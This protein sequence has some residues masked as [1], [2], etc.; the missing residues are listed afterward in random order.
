[1]LETIIPFYGIKIDRDVIKHLIP[2]V[3]NYFKDLERV[4]TER[5]DFSK[6]AIVGTSSYTTSLASSLF[7]LRW[8]KERHSQI[9]TV[10]GGGVF[11]NDLALGSENLDI[12]IR[13]YLYVDHVIIGEGEILL[14]E[15]ARGTFAHKRIVSLADIGGRSLEMNQVLAPDFSDYDLEPY[16]HLSIEGAR[17]CPFQCKFCSETV[18]WGDYRKKPIDL[19]VHQTISLAERFKN[20]SFFMGDS[21]MN[22][23]IM[24]FSDE[25]VKRKA[26]IL[27]DGYLRA[28]KP[29]I[30]RERVKKWARSG[31]FRVRLGIESASRRILGLMDKFTTPETISEVLKSLSSAGIRTT[32]YWICGFPGETEDD[33][34]ETLE[35]IHQHSRYIYELEPH[36]HEYFPY[37]QVQSREYECYSLY[38]DEITE[39]IKFKVWE[40]SN[41]NPSREAKYDRLR[42]LSKVASD[43]GLVNIYTMEDRY[44][45]EERWHSLSALAR[46]IYKGSQLRR[47]ESCLSESTVDKI[48]RMEDSC[49]VGETASDNVV[50]C[51]YTLVKKRLAET[52]LSICINQ[53]LRY[54]DVMWMRI[55]N[56]QLAS[57]NLNGVDYA[58]RILSVYTLREE[59][60]L[61][62]AA[63]EITAAFSLQAR[64]EPGESLRIALIYR[65]NES[66][67]LLYTHQDI[68]DGKGLT[69]LM[70]DLYRIYEQISNDRDISLLP[71]ET[72]YIDMMNELSLAGNS[73]A[74]PA[75]HR[76]SHMFAKKITGSLS[77]SNCPVGSKIT[78]IRDGLVKRLSSSALRDCGL[79][80]VEL[81]TSAVLRSL[82]S[83]PNANRLVINVRLDYRYIDQSLKRTV[84]PLT[85]TIRLG[86]GFFLDQALLSDVA[87]MRQMILVA[88]EAE[89]SYEESSNKIGDEQREQQILLNYEYFADPPWLG[90][91]SW[92]P[93]GFLVDFHSSPGEYALEVTPLRTG[94]EIALLLKY[95]DESDIAQTVEVVSANVNEKLNSLLYHGEQY[96]AAKK[97]WLE[98][99]AG[100][101]VRPDIEVQSGERKSHR[102]LS[103]V[104]CEFE[105]ASLKKLQSECH[106]DLSVIFLAAYATLLSQLDG[107]EDII[108]SLIVNL[109][110]AVEPFPI[111]LYP[112]ADLSFKQFTQEVEQKVSQVRELYA[113]SPEVLKKETFSAENKNS[114]PRP[115]Y[116]YIYEIRGS[117]VTENALHDNLQPD[118]SINCGMDLISEVVEYREEVQVQLVYE[119]GRLDDQFVNKLT[120]HLK[121][122]IEHAITNVETGLGDIVTDSNPKRSDVTDTL[123]KDAFTFS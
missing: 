99:F 119:T 93:K 118:L 57:V 101:V 49:A 18:Q 55:H 23:Y 97:F 82:N 30:D 58:S 61:E 39:I 65:G 110:T 14:D 10:M 72:T 46:E 102:N 48:S 98:E 104:I 40:I 2:L 43:L 45:A 12:L 1:M 35:F 9:T 79:E 22:P 28:D 44:K 63:R 25:L 47:K 41:S 38:P 117:G 83:A 20:N 80:P 116:G 15:L 112:V 86:S 52:T 7:I 33:F 50:A 76:L 36:P 21:L 109:G 91:D 66:H 85:R 56:N 87:R 95:K 71:V 75:T 42:R 31:C 64:P 26:D 17:S 69:L 6:F 73:I 59:Q 123:A 29:V 78:P 88:L 108:L 53:L 54:N 8:I 107:R 90:G 74:N 34:Q 11:A 103:S 81:L 4:M 94:E 105:R 13:D 37:G 27:Y 5:F 100:Y 115:R 96:L 32:T 67:V 24:N 122:I 70:E 113:F 60:T 111:R 62:S 89:A 114:W 106:T 19:F 3:R 68:S 84:G 77:R 120:C 16:Y 51:Y 121:A 92:V